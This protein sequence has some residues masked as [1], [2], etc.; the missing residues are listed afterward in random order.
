MGIYKFVMRK[1][2][3]FQG[4]TMICDDPG[5]LK[6][7]HFPNHLERWQ[8]SQV[9]GK[10]TWT[11]STQENAPLS[12]P[13]NNKAKPMRTQHEAS[14]WSPE[15]NHFVTFSMKHQNTTIEKW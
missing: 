13:G 6:D 12:D 14:E 8:L 2:E 5:N 3:G 15:I 10:K 7:L 9:M 11:T 1:R 4:T